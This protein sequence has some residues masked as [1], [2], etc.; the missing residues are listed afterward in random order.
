[1]ALHSDGSIDVSFNGI[2]SVNDPDNNTPITF[3][4]YPGG[5]EP[6]TEII[7]FSDDLPFS[8]PVG[9]A[10][11]ETYLDLTNP[12][13]NDNALINRFYQIYPDSFFQIVFFSNFIQTM[14]GFANEV[15]IKNVVEGIG[16][17]TFDFSSFFGSNGVLESRCNMNQLSVWPTDPEN[18]FFSDG[19]NFLTLMG[20]EAG[21]RWGAFANFVDTNGDTSNLILGRADAHW[22]YYFDSDHSSLEGGNWQFSFGNNYTTPTQIDFFSKSTNTS[23]V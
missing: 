14:A 11:F 2:T 7:S 18:R 9:T 5:N 8:G 4:I 21:H 19:N 1:M 17:G 16:I 20:Q 6:N 15:T 13:V 12:R 22:S 23:W 10:I 3:G